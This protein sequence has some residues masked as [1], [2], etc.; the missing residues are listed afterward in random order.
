MSFC[1]L[2]T[3]LFEIAALFAARFRAA[4][5]LTNT[6]IS[7]V[8]LV[9]KFFE[10]ALW[11]ERFGIRVL[12][13]LAFKFFALQMAQFSIAINATPPASIACCLSLCLGCLL[14]ALFL[15]FL[16]DPSRFCDWIP[17]VV[18]TSST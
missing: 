15:H 18:A 11:W 6:V 9:F 8:P 12:I 17:L 3:A 4:S 14:V 10:P 2:L 13:P 16:T 1:D 7:E 5:L